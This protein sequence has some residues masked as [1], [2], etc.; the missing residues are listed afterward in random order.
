V[1]GQQEVGFRLVEQEQAM[2]AVLDGQNLLVVVLPTGGGKSL[3]FT[4]LV[5]V[6]RSGV[7]VVVVLYWALMDN[8]VARIWKSGVEC[9]EWKH[10]EVNLASV[11]VVSADVAGDIMSN[12]NFVAYAGLLL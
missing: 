8:L 10:G 6:E 9:I 7:T 11:V 12:G 4:V 2:H 1:L 5:V 3:L